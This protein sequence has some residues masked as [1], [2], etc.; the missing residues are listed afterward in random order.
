M[1]AAGAPRGLPPGAH[2]ETPRE[3]YATGS[4]DCGDARR[5][6]RAVPGAARTRVS[7]AVL[8]KR[9]NAVC[10]TNLSGPIRGRR[11]DA[12]AQAQA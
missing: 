7:L 4:N 12:Q 8:A 11:G 3:P 1:A 6:R 10:G 9:L 5:L 2:Q